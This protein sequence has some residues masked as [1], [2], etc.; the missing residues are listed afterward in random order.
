[1]MWKHMEKQAIIILLIKFISFMIFLE[2]AAGVSQVAGQT[3]L[4]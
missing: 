4:V 1:M 3:I 2:L